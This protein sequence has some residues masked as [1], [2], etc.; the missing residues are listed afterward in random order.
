MFDKKSRYAKLNS[1]VMKDERN[2]EVEVTPFAEAPK[3]SFRGIHVTRQ[4]ERSDHLA[5]F[6][7]ADATAYWRL[8]EMAD[9]MTAEVLTEKRK[10]DI[11]N[12]NLEK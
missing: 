6:Y 12:K 3:Q 10:I 1:L 7:L 5:A 11:P 4:G 2:R 8:A 9:A